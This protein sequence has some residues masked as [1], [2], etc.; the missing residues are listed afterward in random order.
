MVAGTGL[1]YWCWFTGLR[2]MPAGAVSLIGL[3]NPVVGTGLGVAVAG[4]AF[5]WLQAVGM[6]LVL[7]GVV[8]GQRSAAGERANRK[9]SDERQ[10]MSARRGEMCG[11]A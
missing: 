1:A 5:G 11:A 4:E 8:A 9:T 2:A 6:L 3:V 10:R 7:G